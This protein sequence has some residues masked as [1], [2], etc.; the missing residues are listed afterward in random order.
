MFYTNVENII[1][2]CKWKTLQLFKFGKT[3]D[4]EDHN[5]VNVC[6]YLHFGKSAQRSK[7][8]LNKYCDVSNKKQT[9]FWHALLAISVITQALLYTTPHSPALLQHTVGCNYG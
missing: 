6:I 9:N 8:L 1:D 5:F 3:L 4:F 2:L 7:A